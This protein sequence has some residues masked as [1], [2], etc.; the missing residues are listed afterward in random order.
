MN[1]IIIEDE[2][3]LAKE[4]KDLIQEIEPEIHILEV[5]PSVKTANKWLMS[6]AEP[7]LIFADIQLNDGV[8]F[9]IFERY[10]L[11][12]PIIFTTAYDEYAL[13]AFKVNGI[14]YLLKPIDK[15]ELQRAIEKSKEIY[16]SKDSHAPDMS[17]LFE[18]LSGSRQNQN[19][20]KEKFIVKKLNNR[21]PVYVDEIAFF[22]KDQINYLYTN[23]GEKFILDY[24]TLDEVEELVDPKLFYRANRQYIISSKAIN[25]YK[26]LENQKIIISLKSPNHQEE[27]DISREKAPSFRKWFE[28]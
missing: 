19:R 24:T 25:S 10:S 23:N 18:M 7:D 11:S 4:L 20:Y 15:L 5:L 14:D 16:K 27:I 22:F 2:I 28:D 1:T 21:L 12:C 17:K 13:R 9:E 6:H 26:I 3:L 8:S